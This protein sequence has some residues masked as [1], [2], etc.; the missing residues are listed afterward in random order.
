VF[1]TQVPYLFDRLKG[2]RV[3]STEPM[4]I[5]SSSSSSN[6]SEIESNEI[7]NQKRS[8]SNHDLQ[9][10]KIKMKKFVKPENSKKENQVI[11]VEDA[12]E[13]DLSSLA[14]ETKK[15]RKNVDLKKNDET[16][17]HKYVLI[18]QASENSG[19]GKIIP[20]NEKLVESLN[21]KASPASECEIESKEFITKEELERNR[22][23]V[24]ELNELPA[25]KN[26]E[27][28]EPNKRLYIK[29]LSKNVDESHLKWIYGRYVDFNNDEEKEL[30]DIR[31]MK[32]GRMKGQAFVTLPNEEK[33]NRAL[34]ET[35]GYMLIDKPIAVQFA[36]SAKPKS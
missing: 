19:F 13:T 5:E 32:E 36:R 23:P 15:M 31:L 22:R 6:E 8:R 17:A 20:I 28:G 2:D 18:E 26:Y 25:F 30:F 7:I 10:K 34:N 12:F 29:N 14:I 21:K 16:E 9:P 27:K 33:A 4:V 1:T 11:S 24:E 35:N 3:L